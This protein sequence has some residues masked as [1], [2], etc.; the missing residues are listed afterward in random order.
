MKIKEKLIQ[1]RNK[2]AHHPIIIW[3][4]KHRRP[5]LIS[6]GV[7]LLASL[8]LVLFLKLKPIK[9]S[10]YTATYQVETK[11]TF[12]EIYQYRTEKIIV[13]RL[14][15][16]WKTE[17]LVN[18]IGLLESTYNTPEGYTLCSQNEDFDCQRL[19]D[20]L[21]KNI[22][23][24]PK[25]DGLNISRPVTQKINFAGTDRSCRETTYTLP[26]ATDKNALLQDLTA[27]VCL[28]EQLRLPLTT[29]LTVRYRVN[30]I[31][32][33]RDLTIEQTRTLTDLNLTP[34]LSESDFTAPAAD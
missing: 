28:D 5:L 25:I 27:T 20:A 15:N 16:S 31:T 21:T 32:E 29:S 34:N 26:A 8:G 23:R 33:V 9:I 10:P 4:V 19:G 18:D 6:A 17:R 14:G 30:D 7:I 24:P 2:L 22:D 1:V 3:S 13:N 12:G 11:T